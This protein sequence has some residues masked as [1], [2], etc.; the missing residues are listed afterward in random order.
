MDEIRVAG[1]ATEPVIEGKAAV[2]GVPSEYIGFIE[3][4]EAGFFE[5]VLDNDVRALFNHDANYV[6]GRTTSGTLELRDTPE[7]LETL[8][9]P[10]GTALIRDLVLEPM[11]RGDIN[12]MSFAFRV[13]T[14]G[15]EWRTDESDLF[16]R[17]LKKGGCEQLFDV[18]VVTDPAFPQTSAQVRSKLQE[19]RSQ[20]AAARGQAAQA[21]EGDPQVQ[22]RLDQMRRELE[23]HT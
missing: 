5:G 13:K 4:I 11:R 22:A 19:L 16:H 10:P 14:G 6:M 23:L 1:T 2:Y 17:T 18:S 20:L 12:Q 7:A 9:R 21:K 8:I 3:E 15:D